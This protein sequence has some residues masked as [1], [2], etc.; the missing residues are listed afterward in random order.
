M[1]IVLGEEF[2]IGSD[3]AVGPGERVAPPDCGLAV[4]QICY[5]HIDVFGSTISCLQ[6]HLKGDDLVSR[7]EESHRFAVPYRVVLSG[8]QGTI[9]VI[10]EDLLAVVN[11]PYVTERGLGRARCGKDQEGGK[12]H[13]PG[14]R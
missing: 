2:D 5:Q 8:L 10:A 7:C 9:Y 11:G 1:E 14:G 13:K 12:Q 3:R 6:D 4:C